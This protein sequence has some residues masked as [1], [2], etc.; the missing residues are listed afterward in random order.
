MPVS[1]SYRDEWVAAGYPSDM[2]SAI[3]CRPPAPP[4]IRLYHL[5]SPEHALSNLALGR[6]KVARFS[7]LNDPFELMALNFRERATRKVVRD[8]KNAY[9]AHSGV[10]CFSGNWKDPLLWSHYAHKHRGICLGFDVPFQTVQ[11]VRYKDDRLLASLEASAGS[12]MEIGEELQHDLLCT[13]YAGWKYEHEY[14]RFVRLDTTMTQGALNFVPF[15]ADLQLV[16]V[17]LGTQCH[18]PLVSV[19]GL[20]SS[21]YPS[22]ITYQAR[23][24]FKWFNVVPQESTVP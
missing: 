12:P 24:A 16:E 5:T 6:L 10:L 9:D 3:G 11:K 7:D 2:A 4:L 20:V 17:I 21:H 19:R 18:V 13:K 15:G 8:F 14:R 1:E 22:A 23:L